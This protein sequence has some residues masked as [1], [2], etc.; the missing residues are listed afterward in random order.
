M[1]KKIIVAAILLAALVLISG[2]GKKGGTLDLTSPFVGGTTGLI[3]D[4]VDLRADVFDGGRD[5]FDVT[6]KLENKG[7]SFT[8]K[9]KVTIKLTG[10]NPAEFATVEEKLIIHPE[11]DLMEV[12]KDNQGNFVPSSPTFAIFKDMNHYSPIAGTSI[13]YTLRAEY[14]YLYSTKAVSK[15]CVRSNILAPEAGGI[16]EVAGDKEVFNSGG[17]IQLQNFKEQARAK[18]KISF[19]FDVKNVGA[20]KVYERNTNCDKMQRKSTD[21]IYVKVSANMPGLTCSGLDA[22]G[23][24]AEGFV[25]LFDGVRLITCTQTIASPNDFEQVVA[26]EVNYDYEEY[27]QTSIKVKHSGD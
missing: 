2:C 27:K 23:T 22:S 3:G 17:P 16:C 25:T 7:E 19:S 1:N 15:L 20:G 6:F 26:V 21:R 8:P 4:F 24:T 18:D 10:V 5:P 11:D 13:D 9:D 14:C 12:K